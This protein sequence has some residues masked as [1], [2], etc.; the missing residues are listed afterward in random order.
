MSGAAFS[1]PAKRYK[2]DRKR[3]VLDDFDTEALRRTVHDFYREKKY[4]TLD[5]ILEAAQVKG[6][7]NRERVTLW[8]VLRKMG[9]KHKK[10]NDKR[11]IYEQP[12]IIVHRHEYLR[13]LRR[14]RRKED[15]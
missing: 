3:I 15:Q 9:F 6:L 4:P 10:V 7:F 13:R 14:N 1:S 11:Y 2:K 8:R 12:R 5:S